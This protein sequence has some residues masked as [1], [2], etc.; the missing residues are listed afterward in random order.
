M[1][2]RCLV[3]P[4]GAARH[5]SGTRRVRT[6][7]GGTGARLSQPSTA[8]LRV[9][10][11]LEIDAYVSGI[12]HLGGLCNILRRAKQS[13]ATCCSSSRTSAYM[14]PVVQ[15]GRAVGVSTQAGLRKRSGILLNEGIQSGSGRDD[16]Q[17]Q[18][19]WSLL[20]GLRGSA[21]RTVGVSSPAASKSWMSRPSTSGCSP[22]EKATAS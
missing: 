15:S 12:S 20:L 2:W 22:A 13:R 18:S 10:H 14:G 5:P 7:P 16:V 21:E 3:L 19:Q 1:R 9:L 6:R 4:S 17:D 8:S 11:Y